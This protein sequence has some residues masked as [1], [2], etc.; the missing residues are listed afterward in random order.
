MKKIMLIAL[1]MFILYG[2]APQ[3]IQEKAEPVVGGGNVV[4]FIVEG[5]EFSFNPASISARPGD[6]VRITFKN[7]GSV[8][9]T[10]TIDELGVDTGFVRAGKSATVEFVAPDES[11]KFR[12]YCAVPG[13]A[14]AGM[15][16]EVVISG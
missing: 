10:Y 15:V 5:D 9:H 16:G 1:L 2:C 11:V 12:S 3:T 8:A 13:H 6:I 14:K 7:V 4:D